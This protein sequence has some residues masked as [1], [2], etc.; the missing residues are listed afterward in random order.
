MLSY[1]AL[2]CYWICILVLLRYY[3]VGKT[4]RI[5]WFF[6]ITCTRQKRWN[7][8]HQLLFLTLHYSNLWAAVRFYGL[9]FFLL[10]KDKLFCF[11]IYWVHQS[12]KNLVSPP[13]FSKITMPMYSFIIFIIG[14][15]MGICTQDK[16]N[17]GDVVNSPFICK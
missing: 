8:S 13:K 12:Y 2:A 3:W 5:I 4:G 9:I 17:E 6:L 16:E 15:I 11:Y 7:K 14:P 10:E 1:L